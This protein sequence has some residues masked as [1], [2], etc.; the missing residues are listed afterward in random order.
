MLK[1]FQYGSKSDE[2]ESGIEEMRRAVSVAGMCRE[3]AMEGFTA[4]EV[5]NL[6]RACWATP[7]DMLPDELNGR[8]RKYAARH[9]RV[10]E[11]TLRRLAK[12]FG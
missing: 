4:E 7:Y 10:D 2:T 9:G 8:E 11:K 1:K 3:S 12:A 6:F 5:M